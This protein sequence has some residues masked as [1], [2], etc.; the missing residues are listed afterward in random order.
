M[1]SGKNGGVG[2]AVTPAVGGPGV[3][4]GPSVSDASQ[5]KAAASKAF[6]ENHYREMLRDSRS[7]APRTVGP[8]EREPTVEDF[9]LLKCIGRGAFGE[10]YVCHRIGDPT[11]QLYALKRMRK[12]DMIRKRQVTHVRSEKDVLSEAASSNP[13]VVRLYVSFQDDT[14]LYMVMEYMPG[15][16]MISWLCD[17]GSFPVDATRFYIAELSEAV[18]SVHRMFFVHRDIKPD[19]I[20]FGTDGHIKLSDFGLSK[21]FDK[22]KEELLCFEDAE[23]TT[24]AD[25]NSNTVASGNGNGNGNGDD[26]DDDDD[27]PSKRKRFVSIVGSPGYIAPEI[28]LRQAYGINCDWWSV[29]VIMYEMLYGIPPFFSNDQNETCR[30]ITNWQRTLHFPTGR[31][32]PDE[33]VDFMR[34]LMCDRRDRMNYSQ[35]R[36]HPFFEGLDMDHLREMRALY[37]PVLSNPLDTRYFPDIDERQL[38]TRP[39]EDRTVKEVDP[40]GVMFADFQFNYNSRK[41]R[42][43]MLEASAAGQQKGKGG[44]PQK[45]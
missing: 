26:D 16:D 45:C 1:P 41:H 9:Q 24:K 39:A 30:K 25:A 31:D 22:G 20:L 29:G 27:E 17:K 36:S 11:G 13:W 32:V 43:A 44:H 23:E 40:H 12:T 18:A 3:T 10:V 14:Y 33:A 6:L 19:N 2:K 15:G 28:L 21:R 5:H 42:E 34:R 35:I 8:R 38:N 37:I 7:G 4:A